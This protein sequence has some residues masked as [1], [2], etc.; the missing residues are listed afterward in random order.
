MPA[1]RARGRRRYWPDVAGVG[2]VLALA[3]AYLSPALKD[4]TAFGSFDLVIPLTSLGA[5]TYRLPPFNR[6]NSD[7]VSQM[8]VWN[9][10]DWRAIHAGQFPLWNG[11]SLL[12]LPHFLNFESAVLSLPDLV[13][14]AV[15][16]RFA[17]LVA[18]LVKLVIAGTGAYALAR[19]VGLRPLGASFAGVAFMLS[20]AFA[21]WLTWP[22]S[23]VVAWLGW[24]AAFA[25][26]AYTRPGQLRH[27]VGLAVA[28]AFCGYGGFPEANAFVAVALVVMAVAFALWVPLWRRWS[29]PAREAARSG[30]GALLAL[31][32]AG[33]PAAERVQPEGGSGADAVAG[34]GRVVAGVVAGALLAM[35][36]WLPG[37]QLLAIA[38]RTTE[39]H[40]A[41]LP[42]RSLSLLLAQG[43]YGLPTGRNPFFLTGWNYYESVS[44]VGVVVVVLALV[45]LV[46]W[47]RHPTVVA[48]GV[49]CLV[50]VVS[51]YQFG[52]LHLLG[53]LL[54]KVAPEVL[55]ARFRSVLGLPLGLLAGI[56]LETVRGP[57]RSR[58]ALL[59]YAAGTALGAAALV[60][61]ALHRDLAA[62]LAASVRERSL[63][64]PFA[65]IGVLVLA[66]LGYLAAGGRRGAPRAARALPSLGLW[67]T[68]A[69]FLLFAGVGINGYSHAYFPS[70]PAI[71]ELHHVVG[72]ALVGVDDT[73]PG[74]VQQFVPVGFYPEVNVAYGIAEFTGH[75]PVLPEEY[76]RAFAPTEAKGG[77]GFFE[78]DI[79][80][81]AEARRD[82][83]AYILALPAAAPVPGARLVAKIAGDP[84]YAV[85]GASRLSLLAAAGS[86]GRFVAVS[87]PSSSEWDAVTSTTGP[88]RLVVRVSAVPGWHATIDGHPARLARTD[89]VMWSLALPPGR[90]RVRVWYLPDR[91]ADGAAMAA[92]GALLLAALGGAGWWR[93]RRRGS[94]AASTSRTSVLAGPR[95]SAAPPGIFSLA[96]LLWPAPTEVPS[97]RSGRR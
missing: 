80:S 63:I 64:W 31:S 60:V 40:F 81:V 44:Y 26:L 37:V 56:G 46:R 25:V 6:L 75:D 71:R 27:V 87:H 65:S 3:C 12:G 74:T 22:L 83:I 85:P 77:P 53:A 16:L 79:A 5:R 28:V 92:A 59:A 97:S 17:F 19:V 67:C 86:S 49:C 15:P 95:R 42:A 93:R 76:F 36:L 9:G 10:L 91:I 96:P 47:W 41:P 39:Q 70:T 62:P 54:G 58:R 88:A 68:S 21:N 13:S 4:G 84:L 57:S 69:A 45:A 61:L 7:A 90:H 8:N 14:Y 20:G 33:A 50:V 24:I 43:Y 38:H 34:M 35:P 55:W 29:V 11:L 18:V 78:P 66:G 32:P 2:S 72:S 52:S 48:L 51:A 82:G 73:A 94:V 89:Q 23:D 30:P 1:H